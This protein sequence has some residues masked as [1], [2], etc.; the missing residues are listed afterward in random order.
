MRRFSLLA[1]L[2]LAACTSTPALA[3][4]APPA[5]TTVSPVTTDSAPPVAHT[6][7]AFYAPIVAAPKDSLPMPWQ[8]TLYESRDAAVIAGGGRVQVGAM[9]PAVD[10][11]EDL[12]R[13]LRNMER[14]IGSRYVREHRH[15]RPPL[16]LKLPDGTEFDIDFRSSPEIHRGAGDGWGCSGTPPLITLTPS[17]NIIGR[18][19]GWIG[20]NGVP[21]GWISDD[22]E[23]R[24][25]PR[26]V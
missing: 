13:Y 18:Y 22:V 21:P 20:C 14:A 19:H 4:A 9:F 10:P 23:G 3:A 7:R 11:G 26:A 5:D 8:I 12:D 24:Q 25:F 17:V 2:A 6:P 1:V 16:V 15:L